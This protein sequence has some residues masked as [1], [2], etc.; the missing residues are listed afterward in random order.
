MIL[1]FLIII[2][3][4]YIYQYLNSYYTNEKY[5]TIFM[6]LTVYHSLYWIFGFLF[7]LFDNGAPFSEFKNNYKLNEKTSISYNEL[8]PNCLVNQAIQFLSMAIISILFIRSDF[9]KNLISTLFWIV[10]YYIY[11]DVT[12]YFGHYLMHNSEYIKKVSNH[13]LHHSTFATQ[14]K[15]KYNQ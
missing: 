7:E 13:N 12:F 3:T 9:N 1:L 4:H 2:F 14:V 8:I 6:F 5:L 11:Y 15:Q 10:I